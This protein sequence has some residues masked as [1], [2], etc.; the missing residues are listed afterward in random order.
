[1]RKILCLLLIVLPFAAY[2]GDKNELS[3]KWKEVKRWKTDRTEIN[4]KDTIRLEFMV[5]N[6]YIWQKSGGFIYRG[7]YKLEDKTLD[8]GMRIFTVME[9]KGNRLVLQDEAGIYE[10]APNKETTPDNKTKPE[11]KFAPVNSIQQMAGHWSVFKR[12]SDHVQQDIDYTR[13][14][15]M[16]DIYATEQDGKWGYFYAQRDADNAPSWYVEGYANQTLT[17]N[18]KDRRQF[19]VVKCEKNELILQEEGITYF[20]RQFK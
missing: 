9:K 20:F 10:F 13:Q 6:E 16:I 3:G 15:K 11:E 5:G 8:I 4:F 7:T 12:T 18:G 14:L 19:K 1:M 17:C 2:C